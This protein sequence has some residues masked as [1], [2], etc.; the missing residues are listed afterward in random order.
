MKYLKVLLLLCVG[1]Q[2]YAQDDYPYQLKICPTDTTV[3]VAK[4]MIRDITQYTAKDYQLIFVDSQRANTYEYMYRSPKDEML[5]ITYKY[6]DQ[7]RVVSYMHIW[8][9]LNVMTGVYNYIFQTEITPQDVPYNT[10]VGS[11]LEY[12]GKN[13]LFIFGADDRSPGYWEITF[14]N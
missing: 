12:G 3:N 7:G 1:I 8:G 4:M 5:R 11:S 6:K 2:S 14:V 13:H 10:S 9:E